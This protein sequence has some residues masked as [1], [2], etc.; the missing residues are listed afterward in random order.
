MGS[1]LRKRG[2][3]LLHKEVGWGGRGDEKCVSGM[4][5]MERMSAC[6]T[7]RTSSLLL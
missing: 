4:E 3:L 6:R 7:S 2:D 5:G 1:V